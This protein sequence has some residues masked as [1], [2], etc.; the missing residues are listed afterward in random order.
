MRGEGD[1][2][3]KKLTTAADEEGVSFI[4]KMFTW[5]SL[6]FFLG[7]AAVVQ[8]LVTSGKSPVVDLD[9]AIHQATVNETGAYYNFSNI[10]Y[11][12]VIT[13]ATRFKA[14]QSPSSVNRTLNNGQTATR[15]PQSHPFWQYDGTKVAQGVPASQLQP[16]QFN[17]S[18]IPP[19]NAEETE[20]CLFLDVLVPSKIFN[21]KAQDDSWTR[22]RS[23]STQDGAP[24]LV[25]MDGGGFAA[26]YKHEQPPAGLVARS[27]LNDGEGFIYVAMNYRLGLFGFLPA[28]ITGAG[29]SNVGLLDQRLALE[30]VQK[31]I[32]LFGGDPSRVT[33]MGESAGGGAVLHQITAFG[34]AGSVPFQQAILQSP[35]FQPNANPGFQQSLIEYALTNASVLTSKPVSSIEDLR[36]LSFAELALVNSVIV[37]QSPYGLYTFGP[38][39]DGTFVPD[40]PGKLIAEG[41]FATSLNAIMMG[42]NFN[43]GVLFDSPFLTDDA[44]YRYNIRRFFPKASDA[45]VN[46]IATSLYPNDLSGKYNY[47]TQTLRAAETTAEGCFL[48]NTRYL[49]QALPNIVSKNIFKYLFAVPPAIHADDLGYS[50]YNGNGSLTWE[51]YVVNEK[52]A[53][54][55]QDYIS[56]F[57]ITGSPNNGPE[58]SGN[59]WFPAYGTNASVL[60]MNVT[61]LGALTVDPQANSR[62]DWWQKTLYT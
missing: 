17:I 4:L 50:F 2:D 57:V 20:D 45:I 5:R 23:T 60:T 34:G 52:V 39:V 11:G 21:S 25:W 29:D 62:C 8:A 58:R 12:D 55:L 32:H 49:S 28:N 47:T 16:T 26:G 14:P 3:Q 36:S 9:Y 37:G 38:V 15:C 33:I 31:Y 18:E 24:V 43:E 10:R 42:T 46:Y 48:C 51:G 61:G 35:G 56:S 19:I 7:A 27:Q 53:L 6:F 1:R 41:R 40:M 44:D 30:W 54:T 59:P 13:G 22:K